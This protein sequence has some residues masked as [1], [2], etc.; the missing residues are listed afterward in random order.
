MAAQPARPEPQGLWYVQAGAKVWGPYPQARLARF[1]DERRLTAASLIATQPS[2]PFGPAGRRRELSGLF[3]P[4][5][6]E[7]SP[8]PPDPFAHGPQ[9]R[10]PQDSYPQNGA[11]Q[12]KAPRDQAPRDQAPQ[13]EPSRDDVS[14]APAPMPEPAAAKPAR[15]VST[16][17][18]DPARPAP[19]LA[20]LASPPAAVEPTPVQL[21]TPAA[22]PAPAAKTLVVW[23]ELS[24]LTHAAFEDAL[25]QY[26]AFAGVRL[27]VWLVRTGMEPAP[28]RN[29][30]SKRLA[31]ED[32]L[33][34]IDAPLDR[35][36]WF[37]L[38]QLWAARPA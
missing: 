11:S 14:I 20:R 27:G 10:I 26:G 21:T 19:P 7:A 25:G 12:N 31:G 5:M 18:D 1:V 4:P 6:D 34:V 23:A 37:N 13:D 29:A 17:L 36:A 2:G 38:D 28:L 16:G 22:A 3:K 30:L 15:A 9:D 32:T 35:A 33:L 8:A 24:S